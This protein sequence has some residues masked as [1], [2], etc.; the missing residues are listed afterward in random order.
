M[1][2]KAV[3]L[4]ESQMAEVQR[5]AREHGT[6]F[7]EI[8]RRSIDAFLQQ[9]PVTDGIRQRAVAAVGYASSADADVSV[10]HDDYLAA[11]YKH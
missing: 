6:S 11:A 10:R 3:Q 8:V 5:C 1:V 4:T 7:S 2:R 9:Q